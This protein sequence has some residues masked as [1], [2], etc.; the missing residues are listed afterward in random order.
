MDHTVASAIVG[1]QKKW[2]R[3]PADFYPTPTDVTVSLMEFLQLDKGTFI[4]EP[5]CGDGAMAAVLEQ[6]GMIVDASDI[7][8]SGY[9]ESYVDFLE[10]DPGNGA[11]WII[12]NPPFS[13]SVKF[14]LR[15]LSITPNVAMLLKSQYW[16]AATRFGLFEQHRPRWVLPLTWRPSFLEEERG[17]SP[18]MDVL[19]VVWMAGNESYPLY[20]P[21]QRPKHVSEPENVISVAVRQLLEI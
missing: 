8:F 13:L 10:T 21:L 9:G 14:I 1:S 4:K 19:W 6:Y 16:H 11:D 3:K 20:R 2:K 17:N 15:S 7:R 5:A 12:T 18:L